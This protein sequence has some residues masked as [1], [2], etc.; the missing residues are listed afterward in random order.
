V[1]LERDIAHPVDHEPPI[2]DAFARRQSGN[3]PP[4]LFAILG[5]QEGDEWLALEK[6]GFAPKQS[7][8]VEVGFLNRPVDVSNERGCR[9]EEEQ[10]PVVAN[11][12]IDCRT[13]GLE[14]GVLNP[15]LLLGH[16]QLFQ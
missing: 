12:L 3:L 6:P 13:L 9:R 5:A 16:L 15:E 2:A 1:R 7:R 10:L 11:P 8:G 4:E 14:Y